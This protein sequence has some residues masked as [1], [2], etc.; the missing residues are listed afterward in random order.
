MLELGRRFGLE[1][2]LRVTP[3]VLE[4]ILAAAAS[5]AGTS[6]DAVRPV[7]EAAFEKAHEEGATARAV[8]VALRSGG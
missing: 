3:E 5:A 4:G 8:L 1:A 6:P 7:V 2:G